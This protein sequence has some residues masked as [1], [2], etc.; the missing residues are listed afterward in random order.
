[1]PD[2]KLVAERD[3]LEHRFT[4]AARS[5]LHC[6]ENALQVGPNWERLPWPYKLTRT[7]SRWSG[8]LWQTKPMR[9]IARCSS[10]E[11]LS[12]FPSL[13]GMKS[14]GGLELDC[15]GN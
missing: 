10:M 9:M 7:V 12:S 5:A 8:I 4:L 13:L 1:M 14:T 11:M 15:V 2:G 6:D 3:G